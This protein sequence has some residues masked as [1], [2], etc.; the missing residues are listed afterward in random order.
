MIIDIPNI[1]GEKRLWGI[2]SD[3]YKITISERL[4]FG[5]LA[6]PKVINFVKFCFYPI[7]NG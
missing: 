2:F 1:W 7:E 5:L 3:W 6:A 4:F